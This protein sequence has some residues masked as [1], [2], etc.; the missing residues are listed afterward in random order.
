M[1]WYMPII[2]A[3]RRLRWEDHESE[4]RLGNKETPISKINAQIK[5]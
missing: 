1:W 2:P 3:L 5:I 4:A